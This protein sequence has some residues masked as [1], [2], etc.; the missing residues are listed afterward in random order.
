MAADA[1]AIDVVVVEIAAATA[2]EIAAVET[3]AATVVATEPRYGPKNR[4]RKLLQRLQWRVTTT[5][6]R[7]RVSDLAA[8]YRLGA[9]RLRSGE[10]ITFAAA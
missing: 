4:V 9:V 2:V 6:R 10:G 5:K 1:I 7:V 3:E 8:N